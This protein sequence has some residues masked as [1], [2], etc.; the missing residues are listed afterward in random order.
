MVDNIWGFSW[1]RALK[2][3]QELRDFLLGTCNKRKKSLFLLK[4]KEREKT[5]S[6]NPKSTSMSAQTN[7]QTMCTY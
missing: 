3:F 5:E 2:E 1:A 4:L 7:K 6:C